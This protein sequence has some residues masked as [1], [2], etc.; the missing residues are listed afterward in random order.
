[1]AGC[2]VR[3]LHYQPLDRN[4]AMREWM[5]SQ[6]TGCKNLRSKVSMYIWS[7]FPL[8][9]NMELENIDLYKSRYVKEMCLFSLLVCIP[10]GYKTSNINHMNRH[11]ALK[12]G[13]KNMYE[14][15]GMVT[16]PV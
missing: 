6:V 8:S 13:Q 11:V 1:M 14:G 2:L 12:L 10:C 16:M 5:K 15:L 3:R 9:K 7:T 4:D